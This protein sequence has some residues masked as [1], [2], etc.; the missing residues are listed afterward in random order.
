MQAMQAAE[1]VAQRQQCDG[2]QAY[3]EQIA[4]AR[5]RPPKQHAKNGM[6]LDPNHNTKNNG[7]IDTGWNGLP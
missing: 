6:F 4:R 3:A 2:V 5:G 1:R 7:K